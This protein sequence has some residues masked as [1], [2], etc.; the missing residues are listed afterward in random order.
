M[1]KL[2]MQKAWLVA[3]LL[4][5]II[6][7]QKELSINGGGNNTA[8]DLSAKVT[9]GN[10]SGFVTDENNGPVAG[11]M[12]KIGSQTISTDEYGYFEAGNVEVSKN[13]A[14]VTVSQPGYFPGIRTFLAATGRNNFVRIKLLPKTNSGNISAANGGSVMLTNGLKIALPA[15]AVVNATSGVAYT[16]TINVAAQWIDPTGA[17][18]DLIMPGDL[19]AIDASDNMKLLTT[20]GMAAV[21]LTGSAGEKLQVAPGKKA[22]LTMPLPASIAGSAPANIPLWH[23]DEAKGLWIE[24]GSA[25][26]N[27]NTYEGEV[28]HF[29]FWNCDVPNNYVQLDL[30]AKTPNNQP[31]QFAYVKITDLGS[32]QSA[33]GYTDSNGYV[34]GAVPSNANLKVEIFYGYTCG[35]PVHTQTVSSSASNLSLGTVT[36][37]NTSAF[38]VLTGNVTNCAGA[39][40]TNGVIYLNTQGYYSRYNLSNTGSFN[41]SYL[42]C[43]GTSIAAGIIAEDYTAMQQSAEI[44]HSIVAG[45]NNLGTL[46]ACGTTSS[47]FLNITINGSTETFTHPADSLNYFNNNQSGASVGASKWSAGSI[48]STGFDFAHSGITVGGNYAI[49]SFYSSVVGPPNSTVLPV[50]QSTSSVTITEYGAVGEFIAGTY[51][52]NA[53][54]PAPTNTAYTITGS[55]RI[56]RNN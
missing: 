5:T 43:D 48:V 52:I 4:M 14:T 29:S 1:R 37:T 21:E 10:I 55:F 24:E 44:P 40:V 13:A 15:D 51:V 26:K 50:N 3:A 47:Q 18:R 12:V 17:D 34:I 28:S 25:V 54:G 22:V 31:V 53:T 19:R 2:L 38:A 33:S 16:G 11:A 27:G 8:V 39:P 35:V 49:T 20:Y 9:A 6:S 7:C 42:L 45:N 41:I 36:I 46:Q 23:F 30:T 32:S 56:R